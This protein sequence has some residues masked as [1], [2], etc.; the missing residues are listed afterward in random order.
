M[1]GLNRRKDSKFCNKSLEKFQ[2]TCISQLWFSHSSCKNRRIGCIMIM[3]CPKQCPTDKVLTSWIAVRGAPSPL[4]EPFRTAAYAL[5]V[6][7][8]ASL[9]CSFTSSFSETNIPKIIGRAKS[10]MNENHFATRTAAVDSRHLKVEVADQN[11]P[12][13]SYVIN[14]TCQ[15]PMFIM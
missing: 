2:L 6:C 8:A 3:S 4:S 13:C 12:N 10:W 15:Y 1:R 7:W 11:F 9:S 14:R 5:L